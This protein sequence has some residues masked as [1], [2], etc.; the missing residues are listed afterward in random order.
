L[1]RWPLI[2]RQS[3][4]ATDGWSEDEEKTGWLLNEE[5]TRRLD[6]QRQAGTAIDTKAAVVAA[7][8]LAG[9]QFIAVQPGLNV[10]LLVGALILLAATAGLAY[11]ALRLRRFV[12]VP[13]PPEF[14]AQY[15][16][17][18]AP[19]TLFDLAVTKAEAFESN[20]KLYKRKARLQEW[21]L[22]TLA[23][24]ALLAMAARLVGR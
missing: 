5:I 15:K 10:P 11:G 6:V 17:A 1:A 21:S 12:E 20:R 4:D 9:T 8:A 24:A 16:D 14:Y 3:Q 7:A 22:W 23:G 19:K 13:E 18:A 2:E